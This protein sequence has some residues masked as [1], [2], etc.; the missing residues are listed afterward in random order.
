MKTPLD[1]DLNKAYEAF[2]QDHDHLRKTLMA[3]L[4]VRSEQR[5]CNRLINLL[6]L[7]IRGDT[8][9]VRITKLAAA[10][11][12]IIAV[13]VGIHQ[14]GGSLDGTSVAFALEHAV[15]ALKHVENKHMVM[16]T[17]EPPNRYEFWTKY[18]EDGRAIARRIESPGE[19]LMVFADGV[20]YDY[21]P[22][23]DR[24]TDRIVKEDSTVS[25]RS[26]KTLNDPPGYVE[27][28][29]TKVAEE[30]GV[31]KTKF[32]TDEENGKKVIVATITLKDMR[33]KPDKLGDVEAEIIF[34][35]ETK[36]PIR[37][38]EYHIENGQ[39][40]LKACYEFSYNE[41]LAEDLF[42][43]EIP[44]GVKVIDQRKGGIR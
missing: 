19:R 11:V 26:K 13:F 37:A 44:E 24:N 2:N 43:F 21:K 18:S 34:D 14:F 32:K 33:L 23:Y 9:K 20:M 16:R 39:N 35:A 38:R 40:K 31:I 1:N 25:I 36:L 30:G 6:Q 22:A 7:F 29:A 27:H 3:S 41:K 10:A 12:L 42:K 4:P 8:M 28:M 17:I 5:K 15:E